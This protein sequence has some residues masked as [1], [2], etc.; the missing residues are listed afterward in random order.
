[1]AVSVDSLK[2]N[3]KFFGRTLNPANLNSQFKL[4]YTRGTLGIYTYSI[5][6]QNIH[7]GKS[8]A[9]HT[10]TAY[11]DIPQYRL[12]FKSVNTYHR[13][14]GITGRP[15]SLPIKRRVGFFLLS[16]LKKQIF[17]RLLNFCLQP[18]SHSAIPELFLFSHALTLP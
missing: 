8:L 18:F 9:F 4:A 5:G 13:E 3:G 15:G 2:T 14:A 7:V 12:A 17:L 6:G 1:M 10:K 11:T 16:F